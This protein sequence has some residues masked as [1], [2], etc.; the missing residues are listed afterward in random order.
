MTGHRRES[1][2]EGFENICNAIKQVAEENNVQVIYPV[3]LNPNV[4]EPVKRIL[5][6][7]ENVHLISPQDYVPF[8]YL[9]KKAYIIL[10]DSESDVKIPTKSFSKLPP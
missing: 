2:G 9:M 8:I 1:F 10:T 3:H 6:K 7:I 5:N 4:Q